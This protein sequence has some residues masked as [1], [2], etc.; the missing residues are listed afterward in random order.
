MALERVPLRLDSATKRLVDE[1]KGDIG[2]NTYL[3]RAIENQLIADGYMESRDEDDM[4]R[5]NRVRRRPRVG[6]SKR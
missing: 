1:A 6:G 3:S 4:P 5:A 2:L